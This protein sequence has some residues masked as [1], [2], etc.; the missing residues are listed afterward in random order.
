VNRYPVERIGGIVTSVNSLLVLAPP[1]T[2]LIFPTLSTINI[3]LAY[4]GLLAYA[5]LLILFSMLIYKKKS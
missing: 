3:H 4:I 5:V 1:V 2:S